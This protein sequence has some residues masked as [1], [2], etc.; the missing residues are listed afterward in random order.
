MPC[1]WLFVAR[2]A[3][4]FVFFPQVGL[5]M[6]FVAGKRWPTGRQCLVWLQLVESLSFLFVE[7]A[8]RQVLGPPIPEHRHHQ[9]WKSSL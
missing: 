3:A 9:V 5:Q 2:A 6:L 7:R 4:I 8:K 1:P